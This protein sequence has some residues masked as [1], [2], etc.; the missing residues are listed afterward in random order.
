MSNVFSFATTINCGGCIA[1]VT[2]FLSAVEEIESWS[3]NTNDPKKILTVQAATDSPD[4]IIA[5]VQ[6][7][8]FKIAPVPA[9]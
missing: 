5:A 9:V 1:K 7:A 4:K 2:P 3:V 6:K 8:G